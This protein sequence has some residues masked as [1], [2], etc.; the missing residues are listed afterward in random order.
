MS[1]KVTTGSR[2]EDKGYNIKLQVVENWKAWWPQSHQHSLMILRMKMAPM[3]PML[4]A[5]AG[6]S[7]RG[8]QKKKQKMEQLFWEAFL[9][10]CM[11]SAYTR[12]CWSMC[13]I[14]V[15]CQIIAAH[16]SLL[17]QHSCSRVVSNV[18]CESP[19]YN[20]YGTQFT[21]QVHN[22][23]SLKQLC[24]TGFY[25]PRMWHIRIHWGIYCCHRMCS[26]CQRSYCMDM[27]AN[28]LLV[29]LS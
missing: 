5:Y 4:P 16:V 25:R 24:L 9:L 8:H 3:T 26:Y 7:I 27:H 17:R 18:R 6:E 1:D 20:E 14:H 23:V 28:S 15:V 10:V 22:C 11:V 21:C 2:Q 12:C 13:C 29:K 19:S